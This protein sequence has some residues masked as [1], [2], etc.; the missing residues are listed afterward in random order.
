MPICCREDCSYTG[1]WQRTFLGRWLMNL[2]GVGSVGGS[3]GLLYCGV[4]LVGF[5]Q[6][7]HASL[8]FWHAGN[9]FFCPAT[10]C[11]VSFRKIMSMCFPHFRQQFPRSIFFGKKLLE[12][13]SSNRHSPWS[14]CPSGWCNARCLE[15]KSSSSTLCSREPWRFRGRAILGRDHQWHRIWL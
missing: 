6:N 10:T 5:E 14:V 11:K 7:H 13:L 3:V 2:C 15:A 12:S 9:L 8:P 4:E 1:I